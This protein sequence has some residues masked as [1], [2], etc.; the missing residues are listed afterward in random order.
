MESASGLAKW[1][2]ALVVLA[3]CIISSG[4]AQPNIPP[5]ISVLRAE[6][7][8]VKT[9]A[10]CEVWCVAD[11]IDSTNLTYTWSASGGTFSGEGAT[12]TW[13]APAT[14]GTYTIT[15]NVTD[16]RGGMDS[17]ALDIRVRKPG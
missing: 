15:V 12:V 11:D 1:R 8:E 17:K 7:N 13:L 6:P 9:S 5:L 3:A 10:N 14:E 2:V 4:C 16:D